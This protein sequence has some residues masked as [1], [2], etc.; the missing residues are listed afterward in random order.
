MN[1]GIINSVTRLHL[2]GCF[3]WIV[4]RCTD[5]WILNLK[6]PMESTSKI[7]QADNYW[8]YFIRFC[9]YFVIDIMSSIYESSIIRHYNLIN[10]LIMYF[11]FYCVLKLRNAKAL[12]TNVIS[13]SGTRI[14]DTVVWSCC[15]TRLPHIL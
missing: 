13:M 15:S 8:I 5:P 6:Y 3:Y 14:N 1:S 10:F 9:I 2:V 12:H 11:A 7:D 4:L